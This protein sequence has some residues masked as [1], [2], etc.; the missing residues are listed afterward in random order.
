MR[1]QELGVGT[2]NCGVWK[3]QRF[4]RRLAA[5]DVPVYGYAECNGRIERLRAMSDEQRR[6]GRAGVRR[7]LAGKLPIRDDRR[8]RRLELSLRIEEFE[9]RFGFGIVAGGRRRFGNLDA[10][11]MEDSRSELRE[12]L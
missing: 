12:D 10:E 5:F 6:R 11:A 8:Q 3:I 1:F 7:L 4:G 9:Q 2:L